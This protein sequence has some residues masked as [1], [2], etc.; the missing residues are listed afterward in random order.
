[1]GNHFHLEMELL[2]EEAELATAQELLDRY[3]KM[4]EGRKPPNSGMVNGIRIVDKDKTGITRLRERLGDDSRF[5]QELKQAFSRYYNKKYGRRGYFWD[6]RFDSVAL[7]NGLSRVVGSGY[8]ETNPVK[9]KMSDYPADYKWCSEGLRKSDPKRWAELITP[10]T[11]T[12]HLVEE[13]LSH[14]EREKEYT[15]DLVELMATDK[16]RLDYLC[17]YINRMLDGEDARY[18]SDID[19]RIIASVKSMDRKLNL[20][21]FFKK[22][23]RNLT[24]GVALGSYDSIRE[25]QKKSNRKRLTPRPLT[26]VDVLFGTWELK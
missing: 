2:T 8:I 4:Y 9:V 1:M 21:K 15:V 25:V 11:V 22:G 20:Q 16:A 12:H 5:M 23:A 19:P 13:Y 18:D 10:M 24:Y 6:S 14:A 17:V 26:E 3:H 7:L